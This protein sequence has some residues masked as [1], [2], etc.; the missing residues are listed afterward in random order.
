MIERER[1][2]IK[3]EI[4]KHLGVLS[5]SPT[6]WTK[7][8]NIVKWNDKSE[9]FD[10]RDWAPGHD[11]MSR[12]ITLY[13][14]ELRALM[15]LCSGLFEKKESPPA[16]SAENAAPVRTESPGVQPVHMDTVQNAGKVAEDAVPF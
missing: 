16:E 12:G 1:G 2:N 9:K 7:E 8:F 14:G 3:F 5:T 6:G 10:L 4:T 15:E 11:R 13:E